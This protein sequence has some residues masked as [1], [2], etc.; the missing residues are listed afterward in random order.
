MLLPD[1]PA[2]NRLPQLGEA[3]D[4]GSPIYPGRLRT[5]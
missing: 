4:K 5:L 2:H 3:F 1:L